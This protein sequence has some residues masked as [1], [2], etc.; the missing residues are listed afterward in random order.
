MLLSVVEIQRQARPRQLSR[1]AGARGRGEWGMGE[2]AH[3]HADH[4]AAQMHAAGHLIRRR[5]ALCVAKRSPHCSAPAQPVCFGSPCGPTTI[6]M[7]LRLAP[8]GG[9]PHQRRRRDMRVRVCAC[10]A[11]HL[12]AQVCCC[13]G[14]VAT[15]G[16]AVCRSMLLPQPCTAP[17]RPRGVVSAPPGLDSASTRAQARTRAHACACAS[18]RAQVGRKKGARCAHTTQQWG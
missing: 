16:P 14:C 10:A 12:D 11:G 1:R 18:A 15:R 13:V 7:F 9:A 2:A 8:G 17:H 4:T 6:Q 3:V 5:T